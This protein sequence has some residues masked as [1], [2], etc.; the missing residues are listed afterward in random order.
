MEKRLLPS[1]I[2]QFLRGVPAEKSLSR[3]NNIKQK[4]EECKW[5]QNVNEVT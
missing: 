4:Y 3:A 2:T 5:T 1:E